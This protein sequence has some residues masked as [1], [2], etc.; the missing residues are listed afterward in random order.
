MINKQIIDPI[1]IPL[2]QY[3][4]ECGEDLN[5]WLID[6]AYTLDNHSE[7]NRDKINGLHPKGTKYNEDSESFIGAHTIPFNRSHMFPGF[8]EILIQKIIDCVYDF[9][10][11]FGVELRSPEAIMFY[12]ERCWSTITKPHDKIEGHNHL[13]H[14]FS[15]S[16]YP[17]WEETHGGIWFQ[18]VRHQEAHS[19]FRRDKGA[20][21]QIT[22]LPKTG[23][24]LMFPSY[25]IHGTE[26]NS[27]GRDRISY[28]FDIGEIGLEYKLPPLELVQR[29]W[30]G[31]E[32][33]LHDM[34]ITEALS[35]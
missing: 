3:D 25:V 27:A 15:C 31:F 23:S 29:I 16:Y 9:A 19:V 5:K 10:Q 32:N 14:T 18:R 7:H 24:L 17:D 8:P 35:K 20:N 22:I 2:I 26:P 34:K 28:S 6:R 4:L 21:E 13:S 12:I 1:G 30:K 11:H 33:C